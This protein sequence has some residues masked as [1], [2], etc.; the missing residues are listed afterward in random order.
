MNGD[1]GIAFFSKSSG[2]SAIWFRAVV[3]MKH[4]ND[5]IF[6][7]NKNVTVNIYIIIL[8][9]FFSWFFY[10]TLFHDFIGLDIGGNS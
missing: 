9:Y 6:E 3:H 10:F 1:I 8:L 5:N 4:D 2:G 7:S